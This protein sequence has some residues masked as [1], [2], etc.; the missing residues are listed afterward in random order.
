MAAVPQEAKVEGGHLR[1]EAEQGE[2]EEP[3]VTVAEVVVLV[4][5]WTW[6]LVR[7]YGV[8]RF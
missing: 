1:A 4:C 8:A 2:V 7:W 6:W 5:V 3:E